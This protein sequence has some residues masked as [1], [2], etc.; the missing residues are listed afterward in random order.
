MWIKR[1]LIGVVILTGTAANAN[2]V[3]SNEVALGYT[4]LA[5]S[6][7]FSSNGNNWQRQSGAQ[8]VVLDQSHQLSGLRWWGAMDNFFQNG[9]QNLAGFE[10]IVWNEDLTKQVVNQSLTIDEVKA[11]ETGIANINGEV[12]DFFTTFDHF[13]T[14]GTY[15]LNIGALYYAINDES[16]W[17]GDGVDQWVWAAGQNAYDQGAHQK[18]F[19]VTSN[20]PHT[21][22]GVW[23][24][25]P[26]NIGSLTFQG[27]AAKMYA[28]PEAGSLCLLGLAGIIG[29]KRRR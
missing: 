29:R 8:R 9:N 3:Y 11:N 10:I 14:S 4:S 25:A 15:Y 5:Y 22:W 18:E 20:F 23:T 28:V 27:G 19:L 2:I 17:N 16:P 24:P 21:G 7:A 26:L 6:N 1:T 13:L 12:Y